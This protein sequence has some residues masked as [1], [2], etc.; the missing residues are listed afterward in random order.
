MTVPALLLALAA[1]TQFTVTNSRYDGP[2]SRPARARL[3]WSDEFNGRALDLTKWSYDTSRNKQGWYN[4]EKQYY[5]AGR[6]ENIQV[7]DG[8]LVIEARHET[9]DPAKYSDWGGQ[10]YTSA[11][12]VSK[13]AGW[14][15]GFYEIRAKLPCAPGTW[16]AIWMLPTQM[17][18]WPDDGE[19]DI[20]EQVGA[21]PNL[22]YASLHTRLFNHILKTQRSAQRLV[23]TSC[24]SFHRYQLEWTPRSITIGV[25]DRGILRVRNDQPGGKGAWPFSTP[26]HMI[27]NLA[28]GGDWAAAKGIDDAAMPQRMEVDYVRVWQVRARLGEETR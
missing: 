3:V 5:S 14:T 25:D 1:Q 4:G 19:I 15:Y 20:M 24:N 12:I 27:L 2:L 8:S 11:K 26:F 16:P 6:P 28:I 17:K 18:K 23:P 22:I 21:E 10:H 9:L 13:G 7:A